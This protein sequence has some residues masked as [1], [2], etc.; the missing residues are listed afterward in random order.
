MEDSKFLCV[1]VCYD[2]LVDGVTLCYALCYYDM[3]KLM[4][5]YHML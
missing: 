5:C 2:M 4:C 1:T 3:Y